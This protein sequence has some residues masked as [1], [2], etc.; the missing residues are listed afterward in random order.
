MNLTSEQ[1]YQLRRNLN[2]KKTTTECHI[3][4]YRSYVPIFR[5]S[6]PIYLFIRYIDKLAGSYLWITKM[7]TLVC[8]DFVLTGKV[9][10]SVIHK[11][12]KYNKAW[13][14]QNKTLNEIAKCT[15]TKRSNFIYIN[16]YFA[17]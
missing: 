10:S 13:S 2:K 4:E 11:Q 15:H 16:I 9:R 12:N 3:L 7:I 1:L 8:D 6:W 5:Q 14:Y 17:K